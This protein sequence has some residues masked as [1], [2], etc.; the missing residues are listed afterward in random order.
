MPLLKIAVI[1][2]TG[3]T[4]RAVIENALAAGHEIIAVARRPEAVKIQ[5]A[6]LEVRRGDVSELDSICE[7]IVGADAVV[8][9]IGNG[10]AKEATR[11]YSEAIANIIAAMTEVKARRLICVGAS[12]YIDE[13]R[14]PFLIRFIMKNLVQPILRHS[15]EDMMRMEEIVRRSELD[16][17]IVRPPRLTNG[18]RTE[19]YRVQKEVVI[20]GAK[21][22][23]ADVADYIVKSLNDS[24][25]FRAACGAAY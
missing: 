4:G 19:F 12:G 2:A 15:Y 10:R 9:V 14:H 22:S 25:T 1:G 17:T 6:R 13:P 20:G 23:R 8:S 7:A 5:N 21:I 3:G 16:W 24:R 11:F 18:Q